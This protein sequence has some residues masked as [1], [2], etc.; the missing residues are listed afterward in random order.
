MGRKEF[1][2]LFNILDESPFFPELSSK[3]R[4]LMIKEL[5]KTYPNLWH[6]NHDESNFGY[7]SNFMMRQPF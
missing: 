5:L 2:V 4:E 7:E 6:H 3:E 1:K